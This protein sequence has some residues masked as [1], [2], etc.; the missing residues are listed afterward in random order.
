MRCSQKAA[1]SARASRGS[2]SVAR[3]RQRGRH[4]ARVAHRAVRARR[5]SCFDG[6]V[7]SCAGLRLHRGCRRRGR[8]PHRRPRDHARLARRNRAAA[9]AARPGRRPPHRCTPARK[10]RAASGRRR[11]VRADACASFRSR[12][13]PGKR[14]AAAR[15]ARSRSR[16]PAH[17]VANIDVDPWGLAVSPERFAEQLQ[18]IEDIA[19]PLTARELHRCGCVEGGLP[20]AKRGRSPSTTATRT[21]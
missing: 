8:R 9:R 16:G 20:Q 7:C 1:D 4:A 15:R 19:E 21:T 17:R 13:R 10:P 18:A 6:R 12:E 14:A 3:S 2:P 11:R 5:G